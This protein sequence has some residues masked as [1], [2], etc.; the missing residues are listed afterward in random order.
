MIRCRIL[1]SFQELNWV[2]IGKSQR[3]IHKRKMLVLKISI[4][5]RIQVIFRTQFSYSVS[6]LWVTMR[7]YYCYKFHT[8]PNIFN[9][10]L[11]GGR[12]FQQFA[13][14]TYIKI[15]SSRLDYMWHHQN[16]IRADLYQGLLDNIQAG[17]QNGDAVGKR[18]V[19]T[20]SFIGGPR[21]KLRRY[22][23]AMALV[24]KYGKPDVFLTMT[25]NPNWEEITRELQFRQTPQDC[26]DI[27]VR[28]FRAKLEEMKQLFEKAILG[29]VQAYTYVIEF[30][31]RG[32]AHAHFLLI[33]TGK[34]KYTCP[35]QY[36][37]IISAELPDKHKYPEL[38]K[39]VVKHMMHGPCGALNKFCPCT[40]NRPGSEN[41]YP[42][43]FNETTIQGKDSYPLY[44][45]RNDGRTEM[46][47]N[48]QLNNRWVVP[49]NP[50]LLRM[51][52]CH[53][54]V[55]ICS[56]IKAVKYLF[57]YIY[58][59]HDRVSVSVTDKVD[60]VEIDEIK[61][62]KDA[63]WVGRIV[64]AHPAEGERYYLRV[65]LNHVTGATSYEDLRTVDGQ[66]MPTFREAA[67]KRGL[68]EADN[69]LDD[70]MTEAELFR[71][72]SSLRRLFTT[73][74]VF[75]EPSDVRNL[76]NNHLEAMSEDYSRN[77]K[78][79]HTVEQMVLKNIRDMLHSMG[80][81]I[82]SFPL[83]DI[84]KQHETTDDIPMV[85]IEETSIEVDPEDVS[86]HKNLNNEQRKAYDEILATVD[87][88][89]GGI[90]FVDGPGGT[91]KTFL[92]MA[93]L[94]TVR[95]QGKIAVATATSGVA[96]S[97]MPGG[98]TAHS[99]FKIPLKIDNGAICSFTKQ[100]GTAKLLQSITNN[101]G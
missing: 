89:R 75:C 72:P 10:I 63:R 53:I 77:C 25:C 45:R 91:G 100:S 37:R 96:A 95:G 17:E 69:T 14:D 15:E 92:Y 9:P 84:D 35:E 94:A 88:Q 74:L 5:M 57:K 28:V 46:A 16:K 67:E 60:E 19:L 29:K 66:V 64:S 24:R 47:R 23:D 73:I 7:E 21:D 3:R 93:L 32:L 78:C 86:S 4:M 99:R 49:Y 50:Y 62:Y 36:D 71:M 33:M 6:G 1:Y 43:P 90:L 12:L 52:N 18:R 20:S 51:F 2:G 27:V 34:Y 11:H 82:E 41:N 68:I 81:D 85:I 44:R 8:R 48:C 87:R 30:Q 55:E 31:K 13:V 65:L 76:W 97:I 56:S 59:G 98:R 58:K 26:P 54:N 38:Y 42:R 70:C 83:P 101:L 39:M 61:Q 22:L 80:K 79:K 40:K